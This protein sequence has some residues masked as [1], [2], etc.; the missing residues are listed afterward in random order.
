MAGK[1][2]IS[3]RSVEE[4]LS[5]VPPTQRAALER[6]RR[7][8]RAAAPDAEETISYGLA[9]FRLRGRPLAGFG[10]S[11]GHCAFYPMSGEI[12]AAHRR[13]LA[14]YSTSK[15]T[16]RFQPDAP[17]PAALIRKLVLARRAEIESASVGS[18][19]R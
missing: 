7:A 17:I 4:Y 16:I 19:R 10:A 13:E 15:G 6:V 9:A 1:P 18:R 12:V 2:R 11:A 5:Q 14:D 3:A 8:I